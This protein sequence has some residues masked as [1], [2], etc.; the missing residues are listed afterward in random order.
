MPVF[1]RIQ[2]PCPYKERLAE[3][4]DGDVCRMCQRQVFDLTAF[5]DPERIAFLAGCREEVCVSYRV[6]LRRGIRAAAVAAAIALPAA[7]AAQEE[8]AIFVGGIKDPTRVEMVEVQPDRTLA[9]LPTIYE[10]EPES[11]PEPDAR[12]ASSSETEPQDAGRTRTSAIP[13]HSSKP[14]S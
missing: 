13:R 1:P 11:Q 9:E 6:P 10:D 2:S 7:A 4:M 12:P 14:A 8:F 5:S 3:I